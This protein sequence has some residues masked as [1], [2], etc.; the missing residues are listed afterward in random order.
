M[1]IGPQGYQNKAMTS[2]KFIPNQVELKPGA[3]PTAEGKYERKDF[4]IIPRGQQPKYKKEAT[5]NGNDS[6]K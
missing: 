5:Q 1:A 4:R 2:G 3:Q 6:S